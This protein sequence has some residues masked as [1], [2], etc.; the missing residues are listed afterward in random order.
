MIH[1]IY[2]NRIVTT[3]LFFLISLSLSGQKFVS[4]GVLK[5]EQANVDMRHYK[6]VL[7]VDPVNQSISG[8]A[9]LRFDILQPTQKLIFDLASHMDISK[10]ELNGKK[11]DFVHEGHL[12]TINLKKP[13]KAGSAL[14]KVTYSGKPPIALRPPWDGGFTW[15]KDSNG[16]PWIAITCQGE[17]V[18]VYLPCKDH[19]SDEPND[20][21]ELIITVPEGLVVAGPGLLQSVKIKKGKST[22]HWKTNYTINNYSILFNVGDFEVVSRTYTTSE[23]NKVPMEFYVLQESKDKA[24]YHLDILEKNMQVQEKYFG[25]YPWIKEKIAICETPHY[26]ME[27]Q[28]MNA[29]GAKFR[30]KKVGGEDMDDLM[31]HELGHEW[32][33]NKVTGIDWSDM[34]IQEG[35]CV[36][37]DALYIKEKGGQEAYLKHMQKTARA[38]RNKFPIKLGENLGSDTTYHSDIY[39][40]GA[41]FM[42]TLSYVIGDEVFFPALKKMATSPEFTYDNMVS[43]D[44]V[45]AYFSKASGQDLKPLFDFYLRTVKKLNIELKRYNDGTYSIRLVNYDHQLPIDIVTDK[46]SKK[47]I[48]VGPR[49]IELKST[50]VPVIDP[51]VYYLKRVIQDW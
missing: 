20:G 7:E 8:Y 28:T 26:G 30:Y 13:T 44:D 33:G 21:A 12:F 19:P 10:I 27:H 48:K 9:E 32:W 14:L 2:P 36:F 40:K 6:G 43:T 35:I 29:Y 15:S 46:G 16:K 37:G 34:W 31:L 50:T 18:K 3:L 17:G 47:R 49:P 39:G 41:F 45:E 5:P 23:G 24:E 22:Y 4:G 51:D 25:E 11:V 1:S 42:H 38:A